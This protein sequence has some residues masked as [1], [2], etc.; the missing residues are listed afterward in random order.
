MFS[1]LQDVKDNNIILDDSLLT[2]WEDIVNS[3]I[4][5]NDLLSYME[6]TPQVRYKWRM[7]LRGLLVAEL[8]IPQIYAYPNIRVNGLTNYD[9]KLNVIPD[10]KG[11]NIIDAEFLENAY[12][13]YL[14]KYK[15]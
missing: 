6:L 14:I 3:G 9:F 2:Y 12:Q 1:V 8:D 15:K 10:I 5:T 7:N 13:D 4:I 11:L